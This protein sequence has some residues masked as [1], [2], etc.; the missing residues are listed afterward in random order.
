MHNAL[1]PITLATFAAALFL[2]GPAC[3]HQQSLPSPVPDVQVPA[4]EVE[5]GGPALWKLADEDTTI[6]L[7]GTV[8]A[9]PNGVEWFNGPVADALTQ[10]DEVVTE[11][12]MDETMPAK[13][14]ALVAEKGLLPQGTTLTSLM[15]EQQLASYEAAMG[16]LGVPAQAFAPLEPWYAGMM[17]SMLPL[18]QQGYSPDQGVE[19]VLLK[20]ADGK[21]KQALETLEKQINV[22]D[23][24]PQQS[25]MRFL[26][27]AADNVDKIKQKLDAM[28]A[29]W[30]EGDADALAV[31][32]NEGMD[33]KTLADALLY[34]RNREWAQWLEER[35]ATPG[36]VFV[37]VGAGH[38]AGEQS[39]QEWLEGR[40][41]EVTRVQ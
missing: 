21:T 31:L 17:V 26:I 29:E 38:L 41:L 10:S 1:R 9:L 2:S 18:L 15:D 35:L 28:V 19:A 34:Q 27:D 11:I 40:G 14:Q 12:I 39:V 7:F 5:L 13:M 30:L 4:E 8:H 37:A 3:A 36:A 32:M 24:L 23:T 16:K 20:N 22:F 6:Y 25:Q 33:D